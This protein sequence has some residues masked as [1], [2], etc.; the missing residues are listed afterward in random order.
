MLNQNNDCISTFGQRSLWLA[1]EK[2]PLSS[3]YIGDPKNCKHKKYK[4]KPKKKKWPM[5]TQDM[6][7]NN[8]KY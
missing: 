5:P 4:K 6:A 8:K 7:K 2:I 3:F 1:Y